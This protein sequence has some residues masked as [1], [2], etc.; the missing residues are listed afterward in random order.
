MCGRYTLYSDGRELE[1]YYGTG[2]C[3]EFKPSYNV[4]PSTDCPVIRLDKDR[5]REIALCYWGLI[6][7]WAKPGNKIRPINAKAKT[8]G[9]KP[10]FRHAFKQQRCLVPANG[11]YE[12]KGT[13]G[14]KQ[15]Y[16]IKPAGEP[17]F[18]FAGLWDRRE[19]PEETI[20]SFTIITTRANRV[21]SSIHSR[22]P[23]ILAGDDLDKW[24][25]EGG[26]DL[27]EHCP[28][29]QIEIAAVST[30]VNRPTH[31]SADLIRPIRES[32][33]GL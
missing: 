24:L 4:V 28:D 18:S 19:S 9:K 31:D 5:K 13:S 23:V 22:I 14:N 2:T 12:W 25:R 6:P 10:F 11:F 30:R 8:V 16:Y 32:R 3:P 15:P 1:R 26:E 17:F 21:M 33:T 27:L 29:D 7:H 20:D